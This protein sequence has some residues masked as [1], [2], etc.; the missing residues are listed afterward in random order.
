MLRCKCGFA[1]GTEAALQRHC[2]KFEGTSTA[3][4]HDAPAKPAARDRPRRSLSPAPVRVSSCEFP[5]S[6][7]H[8][9]PPVRASSL[10]SSK[11]TKPD[12]LRIWG[13]L[14]TSDSQTLTVE[15]VLKQTRI[16]ESECPELINRFEEVAKHGKITKQAFLNFYLGRSSSSSPAPPAVDAE[17]DLVQLRKMFDEIVAGPGMEIRLADILRHK[18]LVKSVCPALIDQFSK[19]D[20]D[21][22]AT[23]SWDELQ[24]FMTGTEGWLEYQFRNVIGLELLKQQIRQFY[25]SIVLDRRRR[26]AGHD[27][28]PEGK[29]HMIFQGNPGT[30][31][32]S[33]ARI[34]SQLLHRIGITQSDVLVEVQRDK[35]VAEYV[36]QTGPKTQKAINEAKCGVLFIDEAYRLS[37]ESGK[38]D[39]GKEAIEQLMAAMN[40]PPGKA[41]IMVFAGYPDDMDAFMKANSGLYRRIAYTFD[42]SDYSPQE[43]AQMLDGIVKAAGFRL[44]PQLT[45]NEFCRLS[46]LIE[47][48]TRPEA[49]EL[50]N[51]GICERIFSFAK[52][53]LDAREALEAHTALPSMELL[54]A[55]IIEACGRIPPPPSREGIAATGVDQSRLTRAELRAK[56]AEVEVVRLR[57]E[58]AALNRPS[59][60]KTANFEDTDGIYFLP[61]DEYEVRRCCAYSCGCLRFFACKCC[62][63]LLFCL[64]RLFVCICGFLFRVLSCARLKQPSTPVLPKS[65]TSSKSTVMGLSK[66]LDD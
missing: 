46:G 18:S 2:Q 11:K 10:K 30:G 58:L 45:D 39:F 60:L 50:M 3:A 15:E 65:P 48:H 8:S 52:Q 4:H 62:H 63:G 51:G 24:A 49:R 38:N 64:R 47:S 34:V 29:Y 12:L 5:G 57:R 53:G 9:P 17:V 33:L 43:L 7:S 32:T 28:K 59:S 36:G 44:H 56:S 54:E 27:V 66:S 41:P 6:R 16:L 21:S 37:Q 55:D 14:D 20:L 61:E 42:F 23:I 13:R 19:I 26:D 35:L 22:S 1:C 25:R 31:K 40:D